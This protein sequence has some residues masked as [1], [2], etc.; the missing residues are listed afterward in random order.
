MRDDVAE[1]AH[2]PDGVEQPLELL[3]DDI[4]ERGERVLAAATLGPVAVL[5]VAEDAPQRRLGDAR[6]VVEVAPRPGAVAQRPQHRQ[7]VVG[8]G[9]ELHVV[10]RRLG[11]HASCSTVGG[12]PY[13]LDGR[14]VPARNYRRFLQE[15]RRER[16]R[17]PEAGVR[18][19]LSPGEIL[20]RSIVIARRV[21]L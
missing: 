3:A 14:H 4:A 16:P 18:R 5:E 1:R 8:P 20:S 19:V 15:K 21:Y 7:P 12:R 13:S 10:E 17:R 6:Q 2:R 9:E 11:V